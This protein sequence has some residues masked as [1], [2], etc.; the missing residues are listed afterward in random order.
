MK[1]VIDFEQKFVPINTK[2]LTKSMKKAA[3]LLA[4]LVSAT[5]SAQFSQD[6][7]L[8]KEMAP[9]IF[10][11]IV[12]ESRSIGDPALEFIFVDEQCKALVKCGK[13]MNRGAR[14]KKMML[15][16]LDRWGNREENRVDWVQALNEYNRLIK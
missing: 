2:I 16:C 12:K 6:S 11:E 8:V 1:L 15:A 7:Y 5:L 13:I 14:E 4:L 3:V 10:I 9:S